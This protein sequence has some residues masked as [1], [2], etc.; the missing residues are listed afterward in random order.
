[1]KKVLFIATGMFLVLVVFGGL[2]AYIYL[3][4]QERGVTADGRMAP[5]ASVRNAAEAPKFDGSKGAAPIAAEKPAEVQLPTEFKLPTEL[6]IS[7]PQVPEG[8]GAPASGQK[9]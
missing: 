6:D 9:S 1:M 4:S 2:G 3:G 7:T 8:L 5:P